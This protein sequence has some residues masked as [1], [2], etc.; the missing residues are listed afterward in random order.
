ME[1]QEELTQ[2]QL[3]EEELRV[4]C[5][6]EDE[7]W[8]L[9]TAPTDQVSLQG[10]DNLAALLLP[11]DIFYVTN[12]KDIREGLAKGIYNLIAGVG[13]GTVAIASVPVLF[14]SCFVREDA[15]PLDCLVYSVGGVYLIIAGVAAGAYQVGRG[16]F[17]TP[18]SIYASTHAL[19]WDA[20][21]CK[22]TA[23]N[24]NEEFVTIGSMSEK[25]FLRS[26]QPPSVN[27]S[28]DESEGD[29][30]H[31]DSTTPSVRKYYTVLG[32]SPTATN[33]EIKRA[34][35]QRARETHPDSNPND[36]EAQQKFQSIAQAYQTLSDEDARFQYDQQAMDVETSDKSETET[37]N[38]NLSSKQAQDKPLA[39][40]VKNAI[41]L[42]ELVFGSERFIP[43]I[44]SMK[45]DINKKEDGNEDDEVK[46]KMKEFRQ[47]K[48]ELT[49]ATYLLSLLTRYVN[50]CDSNSI[51]DSSSSI[52]S[53]AKEVRLTFNYLKQPFD[54]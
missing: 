38:E 34:Y 45:L 2:I 47:K 35:Y 26:L 33:T 50:C 14:L 19:D 52:V 46:A 40:N 32:V 5:V 16:L 51:T 11:P 15:D 17:N 24:F 13:I 23:Y 29:T 48:R 30:N 49:C 8:T 10:E 21:S 12:P 4:V 41:M 27:N 53:H 28:D 7:D 3:E 20:E 18:Y 42:F 43:Y 31:N 36:L 39:N 1:E 22:W 44:G 37:E 25:Q 9:V 54:I 6:N